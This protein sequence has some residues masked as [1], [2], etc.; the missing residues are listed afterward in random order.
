M[1]S[2][3]LAGMREAG[4]E[5]AQHYLARLSINYCTGCFGCWMRTPGKCAAWRD[6]MD[7]LL[8]Q[9]QAAD[10]IVL[11]FPLYVYTMPALVKTFFERLLPSVEPWIVPH[12]ERPGVMVHPRRGGRK[13]PKLVVLTSAGMAE[14]EV[15][16]SLIVTLEQISDMTG[17]ALAGLIMRPAAGVLQAPPFQDVLAPF[18][19]ALHQAGGEL[20]RDGGIAAQTQAVLDQDFLPMGAAMY[21]AQANASFQYMLAKN[22]LDATPPPEA[23]LPPGAGL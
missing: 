10:Y 17:M 21:N 14:R 12:P 8:P 9:A 23:P 22:G 11:S 4:A 3:L 1:L 7:T 5:V 15:F 19:A 13:P 20:V 16:S 18:F 6:D 2:P